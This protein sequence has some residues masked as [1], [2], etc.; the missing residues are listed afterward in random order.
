MKTKAISIYLILLLLCGCSKQPNINGVYKELKA[1]DS[2][3]IYQFTYIDYKIS[4]GIVGY[5]FAMF[6]NNHYKID[7]FVEYIDSIVT[8]PN[9][10]KVIISPLTSKK[11]VKENKRYIR[12]AKSLTNDSIVGEY[13]GDSVFS[14]IK[15][16][17]LKDSGIFVTKIK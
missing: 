9:S 5:S 3:L 7:G 4:N 15:R 14:H 13:Y 1:G 12:N 10:D 16:I 8:V 6:S 2:C 17:Y 11:F